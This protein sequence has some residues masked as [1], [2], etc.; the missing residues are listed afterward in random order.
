M[1]Q[2]ENYIWNSFLNSGKRHLILTGSH[3]AGKTTR[4][5]MFCAH[6]KEAGEPLPGITTYAVPGKC[7]FL[8][9]RI[10]TVNYS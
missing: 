9:E 2:T 4:F 1:K 5:Q 6:L 7:V 3:R 8:K 10:F